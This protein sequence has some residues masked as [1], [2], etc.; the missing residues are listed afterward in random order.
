MDLGAAIKTGVFLLCALVPAMTNA[1][2]IYRWIDENGRVHYGDSKP[3]SEKNPA[4]PLD[5]SNSAVTDE[6][7][8][9]A[10]AEPDSALAKKRN[11]LEAK[12]K[13][14]ESWACFNPYRNQNGSIRA[15]AFQ[16]CTEVKG[17]G[18]ICD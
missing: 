6:Q 15:E 8:M 16:H 12:R 7:R 1:G 2:T 14:E 18:D 17:T 3:D 9:Q 13:F 4:K 11:C 10:E 5:L